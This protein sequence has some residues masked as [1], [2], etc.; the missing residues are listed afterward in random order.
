MNIAVLLIAGEGQRCNDS[1]PKQFHKVKGKDIFEYTLETFLKIP[2][3]CGVILVT[4]EFFSDYVK[5]KVKDYKNVEVTIGGKSRQES[6]Y[7]VLKY[8]VDTN[9]PQDAFILIHDGVRP[10]VSEE[11]IKE[12]IDNK[13]SRYLVTAMKINDSMAYANEDILDRYIYRNELYALQTPQSFYLKDIYQAH[14]E[15]REKEIYVSDDASLL[16]KQNKGVKLIRGSV[17]NFK[18]T[19]IE[20]IKLLEKLV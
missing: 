7:L 6:V 13:K 2:E 12:H 11:I 15:A 5:E 16:V 17:F 19:T 14:T 3:I 18:I 20:D 8:L 1:L 4:S 10:L 9:T